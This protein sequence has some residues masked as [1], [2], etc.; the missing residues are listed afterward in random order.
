MPDY[1][2][3]YKTLNTLRQYQPNYGGGGRPPSR[4]TEYE[5]ALVPKI[6]EAEQKQEK[7][8][9]WLQP[10]QLVFDILSRGQY[11]TA[12][13]AKQITRNVREG[14]PALQGVPREAWQGISGKEKGD[15]STVLWGGEDKGGEQFQGWGQKWGENLEK[16]WMGRR[17]KGGLALGANI[18][19]DPTTYI[20]GKGPASAARSAAREVAEDAAKIG[21]KRLTAEAAEQM[22]RRGATQEFLEASTKALAKQSTAED[23]LGKILNRDVNREIST[24]MKK[25]EKEALRY[26]AK[27]VRARMLKEAEGIYSALGQSTSGVLA[28]QV[29]KGG[30]AYIQGMQK[31]YGAFA[32]QPVT[33]ALQDLASFIG[34]LKAGTREAFKVDP[35]TG[36]KTLIGEKELYGGAGTRA[37]R[38]MRKEYAM[39][40]RYPLAVKA[41]DTAWEKMRESKVGSLFNDAWWAIISNP[42]SPVAMLR[43]TFNIR[44]PYQ[45]FLS[46]LNREKS[47]LAAFIREED[48]VK[49]FNATKEL[50]DE[51]RKIFLRDAW[52]QMQGDPTADIVKI[53]QQQGV[54]PDSAA[55]IQQTYTKLQPMMESYRKWRADKFA[56]DPSLFLEREMG[57]IANYMPFVRKKETT[58][59]FGAASGVSPSTMGFEKKR[60][61]TTLEEGMKNEYG[62]WK[63]LEPRLTDDQIKTLVSQYDMT[64]YL[65]MDFD[66]MMLSRI[67]AQARMQQNISMIEQFREFGI[68]LEDLGIID[69]PRK[70][71]L[72]KQ[73]GRFGLATAQDPRMADYLFDPEV[74]N[75]I[76]LSGAIA[77]SDSTIRQFEKMVNSFTSWWKGW[78]TLSPGFHFRNYFS[79]LVTGFLKHGVEWLNPRAQFESGVASL[80]GLYGDE[81]YS[82]FSKMGLN[83]QMA[84]QILSRQV[85]DYTVGELARLARSRGIIT[86]ATMGFDVPSTVE[87]FAK[88]ANWSPLSKDFAPFKVSRDVGT[89]IES[90]PRFLSFL[91]DYE[92]NA[93][94]GVTSDAALD[95]A[96]WE[97]KK[98]FIDYGD[99]SSME[100]KY[101]KNLIPFYTWLRKNIANQIV[102]MMEF[103]EMYSLIPK[104][105]AGGPE[106]DAMPDYMIQAGYFPI[107]QLIGDKAN[108]IQMIWPNLPYMDIN[109]IPLK[110]EISD[111]GIPIP[112]LEGKEV[113]QDILSSAHPL[114]KTALEILPEQGWDIYYRRPLGEEAPAPKLLSKVARAASDNPNL[115]PFLDGFLQKIGVPEGLSGKMDDKGQLMINSKLARVLDN[116]L[117]FLLKLNQYIE[118]PEYLWDVVRAAKA[119]T[120]DEKDTQL[121]AEKGLRVLSFYLGVKLKNLDEEAELSRQG[122]EIMR[123]AEEALRKERRGMPQYQRTK[124]RYI[125]SRLIRKR[126]LG[127]S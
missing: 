25:W 118:F 44:T 84:D 109:K 60:G 98:W 36:F 32:G 121:R 117:P 38:F 126:K 47:G 18:L 10:I 100:Q 69:Q 89:V 83:K 99:L 53:L 14:K 107:K 87:A 66:K 46:N 31:G 114:I 9:R 33:P 127:V 95:L 11:M 82:F 40:E 73:A 120:E 64:A 49:Y 13:I 22:A 8:R 12:N 4:L 67:F 79:N 21:L 51:E 112:K 105:M 37:M 20:P 29:A 17:L 57:E 104:A 124:L 85:G 80:Y 35:R 115:L 72:Q 75:I 96:G 76:N 7:K 97:A 71:I 61:I 43:K 119:E 102:G 59:F 62:V 3:I 54:K 110:F 93:K 63:L 16:S 77:N 125:Q 24:L 45:Q 1:T 74:A 68:K 70:E 52:G 108:W 39:G 111:M 6:Q 113:M 28:K 55:K 2:P 65:D 88:Q 123:E 92:R 26:P 58:G 15:W 106:T 41:W 81:A 50:N 122:D 5:Q 42:K 34:E 48:A 86:R 19:L 116:N 103:K 91:L 94:Q 101:L 56:E 90:Q 30:Q 78:A 27:E 23:F